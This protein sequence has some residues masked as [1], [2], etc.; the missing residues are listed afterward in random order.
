MTE[1]N[2]PKN[3]DER[4]R[5][6]L[7][8]P[9]W[10]ELEP[11]E[12]NDPDDELL[13]SLLDGELT[14][15]EC[16][17]VERRLKED[18]VF[19]ARCDKLRQACAIIDSLSPLPDN[20][21]L[22]TTTMTYASQSAQK[23]NEI[24]AKKQ[25]RRLFWVCLAMLAAAMTA[26]GLCGWLTARYYARR[27][28]ARELPS[29]ADNGRPE[30]QNPRRG[31]PPMSPRFPWGAYRPWNG[32]GRNY[33]IK[34]VLPEE[35]REENLGVLDGEL[36]EFGKNI[37]AD[38]PIRDRPDAKERILYRF[39]TERGVDS[40]TALL[41]DR[42]K[43]Y[44][45]P[46]PEEQKIRLIGQL[47]LTGL[48]ERFGQRPPTGPRHSAAP[49]SDF[50]NR[51]ATPPPGAPSPDGGPDGPREA[52][53]PREFPPAERGF[54]WKNETTGE[55]AKTLRGLPDRQLDELLRLPDDE[56][57]V[58]L[59]VLHWGIDPQQMGRQKNGGPPPPRYPYNY[60]RRGRTIDD[61]NRFVDDEQAGGRGEEERG[62]A[63][64]NTR[65]SGG[66]NR[67][68]ENPSPAPEESAPQREPGDP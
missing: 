49:P 50:E 41:S 19:A 25:R 65:D 37:P 34:T 46:L 59:L 3:A 33:D 2:D 8:D 64:N 55:L 28:A 61:W 36:F 39:I 21:E 22:R 43:S 9:D 54:F 15:E 48:Y 13:S 44:I 30:A 4:P 16:R 67:A 63:E 45:E 47:I 1:P 68:A 11:I 6:D 5:N 35:L 18:P 66:E 20:P 38:D 10:D 29:Q 32:R 40:F 14:D 57:Y 60:S 42:G 17:E 58:R 23:E 24:R 53:P 26:F 12:P 52:R 62:A 27:D 51:P 56:M 7:P 31:W